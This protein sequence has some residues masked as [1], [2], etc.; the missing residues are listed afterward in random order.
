MGGRWGPRRCAAAGVGVS[1]GV[2]PVGAVGAAPTA[3]GRPGAGR[4]PPKKETVPFNANSQ[5]K[6]AGKKWVCF[7]QTASASGKKAM[8]GPSPTHVLNHPC[9]QGRKNARGQVKSC[10]KAKKC[11]NRATHVYPPPLGG[12]A[13][14]CLTGGEL[15]A[16][17]QNPAFR[18]LRPFWP[19]RPGG[20]RGW[21]AVASS[22][23]AL[24]APPSGGAGRSDRR[25]HRQGFRRTPPGRVS[26][27]K[28]ARG[29]Y[30]AC[31]TH[32]GNLL[33]HAAA[34]IKKINPGAG[35]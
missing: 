6:L 28:R 26:V 35:T 12:R 2:G 29:V 7:G 10:K 16:E 13:G 1:G 32:H 15:C 18:G 14:G 5:A 24:S 8:S 4:T 17:T 19:G 33:V 34:E 20:G 30:G 27:Q 31:G 22:G 23:A 11:R 25:T 21:A 3:A 9:A